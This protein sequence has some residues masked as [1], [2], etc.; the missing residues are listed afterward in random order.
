MMAN[1]KK[2]LNLINTF[3]NFL[4]LF[5]EFHCDRDVFVV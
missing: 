1:S 4:Q 3:L 2:V 5:M